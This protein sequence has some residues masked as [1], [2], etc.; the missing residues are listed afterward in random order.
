MHFVVCIVLDVVVHKVTTKV[1]VA[2]ISKH[3]Q[4]SYLFRT[5][6]NQNTLK[7]NFENLIYIVTELNFDSNVTFPVMIWLLVIM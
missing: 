5:S 4:L 7:L 3:I 1:Y 2:V 6:C